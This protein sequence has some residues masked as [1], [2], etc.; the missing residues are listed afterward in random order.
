MSSTCSPSWNRSRTVTDSTSSPRPR[1]GQGQGDGGA[2]DRH[3]RR[4]PERRAEPPAVGDPAERGGPD[5]ARADGEAHDEARGHAEIARHVRLS[6]DYRRG[7]GRYQHQAEGTQEHDGPHAAHE[8]KA[9]GEGRGKKEHDDHETPGAAISVPAAP[10]PRNTAR[11][12]PTMR[13]SP[14]STSR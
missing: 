11:S 5:A 7:E 6:Q 9:H 10:A 13:G 2:Q 3:E 12:V 14:L 8:E 1:L 4:D